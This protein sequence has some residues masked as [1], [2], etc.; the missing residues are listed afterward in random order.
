[1]CPTL[2]DPMNCNPQTPV[3]ILQARTLEWVAMSFS[4]VSSLIQGLNPGLPYCRQIL[5][6]LS[7]HR[8][9]VPLLT[10]QQNFLFSKKLSGKIFSKHT[11]ENNAKILKCVHWWNVAQLRQLFC[12]FFF[13]FLV[14]RSIIMQ[15]VLGLVRALLLQA[16]QVKVLVFC[17]DPLPSQTFKL[18]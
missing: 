15:I 9:P 13:F 8:N 2:C 1:M 6:Y 14:M 18:L 16:T 3:S 4:R 12:V 7:R 11:H 10:S 17:N 5:Y